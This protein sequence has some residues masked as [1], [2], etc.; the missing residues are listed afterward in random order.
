[1]TN[2]SRPEA[3]FWDRSPEQIATEIGRMQEQ[4]RNAAEDARLN[5]I[6]DERADGPF[7]PV[8]LNGL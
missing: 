8:T 5:R 6:A 2:P 3:A 1:M 4:R 7:I